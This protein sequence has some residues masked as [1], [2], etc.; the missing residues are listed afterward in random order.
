MTAGAMR[1]PAQGRWRLAVAGLCLGLAIA[2]KWSVAPLAMLPGLLFL[3]LK[4]RDHGLKDWGKRFLTAREG[5]PVPG[6][7]LIEAA[8]WL[9]YALL[10]GLLWSILPGHRGSVKALVMWSTYLPFLAL[11]WIGAAISREQLPVGVLCEASFC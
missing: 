5:G 4:L 9:G 3:A 6:I 1:K 2:A 8:F 7:I 10:F 11:V